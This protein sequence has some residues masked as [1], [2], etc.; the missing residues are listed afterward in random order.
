MTVPSS[1]RAHYRASWRTLV[2]ASHAACAAKGAV[3]LSELRQH[4]VSA[5]KWI[6]P[7][8]DLGETA[9]CGALAATAY[10]YSRQARAAQRAAMAG[11]LGVLAEMVGDLLD[12]TQTPK[13]PNEPEPDPPARPFR[14][15]IDG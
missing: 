9:T 8:A 13:P 11:A 2:L 12:A 4:A 5:S 10:A 3:D 7:T 6:A 1:Q 15:D 14:R